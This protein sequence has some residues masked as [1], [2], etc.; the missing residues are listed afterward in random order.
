MNVEL[1]L[2]KGAWTPASIRRQ[3]LRTQNSRFSRPRRE[4]A[5]RQRRTDCF[6]F[7]V[8]TMEFVA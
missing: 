2:E 3:P 4:Q 1:K 5:V 6:S 7:S 8:S